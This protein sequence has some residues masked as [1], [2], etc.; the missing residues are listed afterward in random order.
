MSSGIINSYHFYR[1]YQFCWQI[2]GDVLLENP[3]CATAWIILRRLCI[4]LECILLSGFDFCVGTLLKFPADEDVENRNALLN[5]LGRIFKAEYQGRDSLFD[6]VYAQITVSE[7]VTRMFLC[8]YIMNYLDL[9]WEDLEVSLLS[10]IL[11]L[12][13]HKC[14]VGLMYVSNFLI[15][16]ETKI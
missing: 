12:L 16:C 4:L 3:R 6:A 7:H 15:F 5:I 10:D 13:K 11:E 9:E 14:G 8:G 2:Y 1:S